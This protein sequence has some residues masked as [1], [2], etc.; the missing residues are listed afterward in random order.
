MGKIHRWVMQAGIACL[1]IMSLLSEAAAVGPS[2]IPYTPNMTVASLA[3]RPDTDMIQFENGRQLS[4]GALR[5]LD[6][7]AKKLRAPR[8]NKTPAAFKLEPDPARIKLKMNS[9]S[10]LNKALKLKD[11]E[12][13][14]LP[15]GRLV[16][17]A[18]IKFVQPMVERRLGF[19]LSSL[20][21]QPDT[22]GPALK[23]AP[24]TRKERWEEILKKPDK[25][26][27]ESP[28]GARITVGELKDYLKQH[29][30]KEGKR[31]Q[32]AA[33]AQAPK[34]PAVRRVK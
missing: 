21:Q 19:K 18:Q 26:V 34:K 6:K 11:N 15:S 9:A 30:T 12:T 7:A 4:V 20:P 16:T 23:I 33:P 32:K 2:V 28:K 3:A 22:S 31:E 24:D 14:Q 17:A 25:T 10:D 1:G 5:R 27:I 29:L 13:V 8:V